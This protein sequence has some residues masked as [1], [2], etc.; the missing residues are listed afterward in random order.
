MRAPSF[1][2]NADMWGL[3]CPHL[4]P[5]LKSTPAQLGLGE[6]R[7]Q[8]GQEDGRW[9]QAARAP[10][11]GAESG[12]TRRP[13]GHGEREEG[14][15][16]SDNREAA[17]P[18]ARAPAPQAG[19]A[20]EAARRRRPGHTHRCSSLLRVSQPRTSS[21]APCPGQEALTTGRSGRGRPQW[22]CGPVRRKS[23]LGASPQLRGDLG[24]RQHA[25]SGC[26]A[27]FPLILPDDPQ[28]RAHHPPAPPG[29]AATHAHLPPPPIPELQPPEQTWEVTPGKSPPAA[30]RPPGCASPPWTCHQCTR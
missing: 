1:C 10:G 27:R 28:S 4:S 21:Q 18:G 25:P 16:C 29:N 15:L 6:A 9:H 13:Q 26:R 30:P 22:L 20:W 5:S 3:C 12:G 19:A 14:G 23:D 2:R 7:Q 24:G 17:G 11:C 8:L